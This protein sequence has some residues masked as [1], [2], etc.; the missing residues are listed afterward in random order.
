MNCASA[1]GGSALAWQCVAAV[2]AF[3]SLGESEREL[4]CQEVWKVSTRN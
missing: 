3:E 4:L 1:M 2:D